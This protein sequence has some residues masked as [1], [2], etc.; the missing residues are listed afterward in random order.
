M[1]SSS[2]GCRGGRAVAASRA[3]LGRQDLAAAP[4]RQRLAAR[5]GLQRVAEGVAEQDQGQDG[6]ADHE[7]RPDD[8]AG[9]VVDAVEGLLHHQTPR[10]PGRVAQAEEGDAG[11]DADAGGQDER[12]LD[13][14]R[15]AD[16]PQHVAA[17]DPQVGQAD[18]PGR[19]DVQLV[20]GAE[21]DRSD[22]PVEARVRR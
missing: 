12:A 16:R 21:G 13:D 10:G 6:Q 17:D 15:G 7:C 19:V 22:H 4:G 8:R 14:H 5:G 2:I 11:L 1:T 18:H 9:V 20:A 3:A